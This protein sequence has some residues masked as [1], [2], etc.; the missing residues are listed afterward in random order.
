MASG[1]I[2]SLYPPSFTPPDSPGNEP[3]E[4]PPSI[5]NLVHLVERVLSDLTEPPNTPASEKIYQTGPN[6]IKLQKLLVRLIEDRQSLAVSKP[7][8]SCSA[9]DEQVTTAPET[10]KTDTNTLICTT[11]DSPEVQTCEHNMALKTSSTDNQGL[12]TPG[13]PTE[14]TA[15]SQAIAKDLRHLFGMFLEKVLDLTNQE[16]PNTPVRSESVV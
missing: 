8:H 10:G 4:R 2:S 7:V 16:P 6:A 5:K 13:S 3:K 11:A 1:E 15:T 9:S 12:T 14:A